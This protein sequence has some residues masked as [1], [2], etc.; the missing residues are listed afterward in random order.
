VTGFDP[1]TVPHRERIDRGLGAAARFLTACQAPD[2]AWRSDTYG[3]FKGGDALTP[4]VLRALGAVGGVDVPSAVRRGAAYLAGMVRRD[5]GI[6]AGPYGLSYPT[7]TAALT[8]QVLDRPGGVEHSRQR[9]A[10]LDFLRDRQLTEPLGWAPADRAYGGWGYA[11]DL[12]RRP[13]PGQP[14]PPLSEANLSATVFAVEALRS[15]GGAHD[16]AL[17]A[18]L[19]F[20]RRCQNYA[21]GAAGHDPAFDDG[22]FIFIHDDAD[23]NKAGVAGIDRS[24]RRRF[25]SYGSTTAD[26]LRGLL[27]CGV[28]ADADRVRAAR[29]WLATHFSAAVHPGPFPG[30]RVA[31]QASLYFYYCWS[32]AQA[33]THLE[34]DTPAPQSWAEALA[35][36]LVRRQRPDGCW[37]NDAVE[38]REDEPL[39]ATSLAVEALVRCR[40]ILDVDAPRPA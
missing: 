2:G 17:A 30:A 26:G 25:A 18:A 19:V 10:W 39:V 31:V 5:G 33:L 13:P 8:V 4:L 9:A 6:D 21:E 32:L 14:V 20:L 23:R 12:P 35:G 29:C 3:T 27:A 36:E 34:G 15:A 24:G 7:Y 38:V 28:P 37:I 40:R 16:P 1:G 22:G 11:A